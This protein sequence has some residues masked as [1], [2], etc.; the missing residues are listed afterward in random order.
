MDIHIAK[1]E[2]L[3]GKKSKNIPQLKQSL[4]E[5]QSN[6]KTDAV[7][8]KFEVEEKRS[9]IK[10]HTNSSNN[11]YFQTNRNQFSSHPR[12]EDFFEK[13]KRLYTEFSNNRNVRAV[14]CPFDDSSSECKICY[15]ICVGVTLM[16]LLFVFYLVS[17][18][19]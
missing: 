8:E 17:K 4:T 12:E 19:N 1:Y 6:I 5:D 13:I 2:N 18:Y 7:I 3:D 14:F 11:E 15:K 16:I 9:S 10:K